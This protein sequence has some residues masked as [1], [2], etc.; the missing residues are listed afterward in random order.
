MNTDNRPYADL[1]G[2]GDN[3]FLDLHNSSDQNQPQPMIAK[4]IIVQLNELANLLSSSENSSLKLIKF[5]DS[6]IFN[7]FLKSLGER[8]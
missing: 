3:I 4:Y 7:L 2:W 8:V 6:F 5:A 1:G